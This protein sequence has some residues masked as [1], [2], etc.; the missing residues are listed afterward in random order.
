[1]SSSRPDPTD[2]PDEQP[3]R[4]RLSPVQIAA[5]ALASVSS[6]V[7]ASFFGVAGTLIGAALASVISTVTAAVY[8]NSLARTNARLRQVRG[9]LSGTARAAQAAAPAGPAPTRELP[10]ALDPRRPPA[11]ARRWR[12][13]RVA[14]YAVAVF[15]LAMTIVTGIEIVGQQPVSALVGAREASTSTTLGEL[16]APSS[17]TPSP[18]AP[19]TPA[20]S[21]APEAPGTAAPDDADGSGSPAPGTAATTSPSATPERTASSTAAPSGPAREAPQT[22]A[23]GGATGTGGADQRQDPPAAAGT[24]APVTP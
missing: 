9:Q 22:T 5:G 21:D 12:W 8:T 17:A 23:D 1:M 11:P 4:T 10:A 16:T 15:G 7:V 14:G 24:G 6:A 13:P 19:T 2:G 18:A 20:P 3:E